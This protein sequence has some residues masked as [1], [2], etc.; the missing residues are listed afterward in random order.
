MQSNKHHPAI[1]V[2][3]LFLLATAVAAR[4]AQAQTF[5]VLHTFHADG[6][7]PLFPSGQLALDAAGNLYGIAGG[8][9]PKCFG[10]NYGSCGTVFKMTKTGKLAWV[11]RFNGPDGDDPYGGVLRDARGTLFGVTFFG[12]D[13]TKP[14]TDNVSLGCG[15]VYELDKTGRK[16]IVLHKFTGP[17]DGQWPESLLSEDQQGN[18]YGTTWQGGTGGQG[19]VFKVSPTGKETILYAFPS[20]YTGAFPYVGV[21]QDSSGNLYGT[22]GYGGDTACDSGFGCGTVYELDSA[23]QET[24]LYSFTWSADGA[25]PSWG[26]TLIQDSQGNL[27][28]TTQLGGNMGL[29][30]CGDYE[31]CGVIFKVSPNSDGT[32]TDTTLYEFCP[33]SDCAGGW[34]PRSALVR[35]AAGNLYGT[36]NWG[37]ASHC[38]GLN[39]GCGVV[40]KLDTSGNETVLHTFT[41]GADGA[42]PSGGLVMDASGNIYGG[43]FNGGDANCH[44]N[45]Q[46]GCGVVFKITP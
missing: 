34:L 14:C 18:L 42:Y 38:A 41:G 30:I 36:T 22:T 24:L 11:Y 3:A 6:Q 17:P 31:G 27:Y 35:D 13:H 8:G 26:D 39:E 37:G 4:P 33:Q 12:G 28:G 16:E 10:I 43:T 23:G 21:V 20:L 29:Y 15:L 2:F 19:I 44:V 40:F 7:G 5:K 46:P 32:W 1:A 25:F 9:K 45:G